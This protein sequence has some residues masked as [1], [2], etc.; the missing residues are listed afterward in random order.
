[1][2]YSSIVQKIC[3]VLVFASITMWNWYFYVPISTNKFL[4]SAGKD[5]WYVL[6]GYQQ[7][8]RALNSLVQALRL[9]GLKK[10]QRKTAKLFEHV[11]SFPRI[12]VENVHPDNQ[13]ICVS[14]IL[15]NWIHVKQTSVTSWRW[16]NNKILQ[17]QFKVKYFLTPDMASESVLS[18]S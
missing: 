10:S 2:L 15:V 3:K 17:M 11:L 8:A 5:V 13:I 16:Y 4:S 7:V 6:F 9:A 1:M 18:I 12:H 14:N